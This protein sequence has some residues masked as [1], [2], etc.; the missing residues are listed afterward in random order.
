[1]IYP[2]NVFW[3]GGVRT[4]VPVDDAQVRR[5]AG[6]M[7]LTITYTSGSSITADGV[8]SA[9]LTVEHL[10][11][12]MV[13]PRTDKERKT[14]SNGDVI[15]TGDSWE[16]PVTLENGIGTEELVSDVVG[17]FYLYAKDWDSN[18]VTLEAI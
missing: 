5:M 4:A 16:F 14:E 11:P 10:T 15:I 9:T 6:T 3:D 17:S 7:E 12:E 18:T 2:D 1:M 8:D 13:S